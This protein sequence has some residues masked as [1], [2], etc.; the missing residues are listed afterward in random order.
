MSL[1]SSSI[2][3]WDGV[4]LVESRSW[5]EDRQELTT[6]FCV[7]NPRQKRS[8]GRRNQ[9]QLLGRTGIPILNFDARYFRQQRPAVDVKSMGA[10]FKEGTGRGTVKVNENSCPSWRWQT[11][12]GFDR[13]SR[14]TRRRLRR[15][16]VTGLRSSI[17]YCVLT[18]TYTYSSDNSTSNK[19]NRSFP[20]GINEWA[21]SF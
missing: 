17:F 6:I 12:S 5:E 10:K 20:V 14:V 13:R 4:G 18:Y 15:L 8:Q 3:P 1:V 21:K 9:L 2:G 16:L 19:H 7:T 11:T